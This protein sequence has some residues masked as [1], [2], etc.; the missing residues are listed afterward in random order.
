MARSFCAVFRHGGADDVQS[1][2]CID[3]FARDFSDHRRLD[4]GHQRFKGCCRVAVQI[5]DLT[6]SL[7]QMGHPHHA[8]K[9]WLL[10]QLTLVVIGGVLLV[11]CSEWP[12]NGGRQKC[13][14]CAAGVGQLVKLKVHFF[15]NKWVTPNMPA[16]FGYLTSS[17][18]W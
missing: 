9:V 15:C 13:S 3:A 1:S 12:P 10:D 18:W 8:C 4:A 7:G 14:R 16:K 11:F 5:D 17:P 6:S 2:I